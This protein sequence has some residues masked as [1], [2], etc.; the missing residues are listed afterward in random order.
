MKQHA[1]EWHTGKVQR[2]DKIGRTLGFPT[3]NLDPTELDNI[4][5]DGVYAAQVAVA[6]AHYRGVLYLGPR[7][8]LGETRRVLEIHLV[9]FSGDLYDQ[10]ISFTLGPYI[11]PPRNFDSTQA[12]K[13][14][15][16]ED[17]AAV[18]RAVI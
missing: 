10:V 6:H 1:H 14:Q 3:A 17:V 5:R 11:R 8:T 16:A 7:L 4:S 18:R 12:L 13:D 15:L 9:D 2:G